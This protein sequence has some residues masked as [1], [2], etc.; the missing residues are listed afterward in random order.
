MVPASRPIL[1]EHVG[2]EPDYITPGLIEADDAAR[3]FYHRTMQRLW[4]DVADLRHLGVPEE[5]A[6]YAL[7]NALALRFTETGDLQNLH[8]KWTSRLCYNAQEE[9]FAASLDEV[10]QVA[11]VHP[12][13]G[14][15]LFAPCGLRLRAGATPYCPEGERYC[16]VPVWKLS[17]GQ[18]ER[19]I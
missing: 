2:A 19:V 4:E 1:K 10:R 9:I 11:A 18:Y 14:R 13:I 6:L 3:A 17:I 12:I 7:P 8:H 15:Y 16:G 5:F